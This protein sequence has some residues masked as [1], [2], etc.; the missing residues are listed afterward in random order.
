M[1]VF[2]VYKHYP[3]KIPF[4]VKFFNVF[5]YLFKI[6]FLETYLVAHLSGG[7]FTYWRRFIPPLYFYKT[8][9][10]R[11]VE[12][13][14]IKYKL[15][16]S[17]LLDHSIYFYRIRDKAWDNLF[18]LLEK[19]FNVID[20][21]ANIGFLSLNF[22]VRCPAGMIYA[23]EPDSDT[24]QKLGE[25]VRLNNIDN[26]R[27]YKKALGSEPGT[28]E[29][30]KMY[31]SN[32]GA[33]RILSGKPPA[34][35]PSEKVEI[36]TLDEMDRERPFAG[37]RLL[38]IDVEGFELFVIRGGRNLILKW[39]PILFVKLVDQNL[40]QQGC[41]AQALISYI[42]QMGYSIVDAQSMAALIP[43]DNYYTDIICFPG[44]N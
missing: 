38:K 37:V 7:P 2:G 29:L 14:S 5:R 33:N 28:G 36:S 44:T 10:I 43:S 3:F 8:G 21:G 32:P 15:D 16:I 1:T 18:K 4:R 27:V 31:R 42:L 17:T 9:S 11:I 26:I 20:V 25:N 30:Y 22:A 24:F 19:D 34:V 23:F 40:A 12:R 41:S 39:K 35:I 6:S 13:H